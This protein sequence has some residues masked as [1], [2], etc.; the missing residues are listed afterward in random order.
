MKKFN[1]AL[2]TILVIAL[3]VFNSCDKE[4][5]EPTNPILGTWE[6]TETG[7]GYS[8][9]L[10]ITFN[11]NKTGI[12]KE[13]YIEDD[14]TESYTDNFTYS[15]D[16]NDLVLIIDEETIELTYSVSGNKLTIS[17]EG[18]EMLIFTKK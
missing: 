15:T 7:D 2:I 14:S 8:F 18:E 6:L 17:E 10:T 11:A 9:T 3:G 12:L 5:D 13:E 1:L 4:E 16:N